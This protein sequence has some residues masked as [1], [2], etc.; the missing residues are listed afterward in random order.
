MGGNS[1]SSAIGSSAGSTLLTGLSTL[2]LLNGKNSGKNQIEQLRQNTA[3]DIQKRRNL[4]E[5]QLA[6]RRAGLGSLGITGSASSAAVEQRL[7]GEAYDD[8]EASRNNYNYR[9]QEIVDGYNNSL[10]N[11][12]N[13]AARKFQQLLTASDHK[14]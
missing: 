2:S 5:Q 3:A 12:L 11:R 7:A 8:M 10:L 13:T 14:N 9:S 1:V 6:S 4:L